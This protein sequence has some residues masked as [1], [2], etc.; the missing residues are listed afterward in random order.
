MFALVIKTFLRNTD[1]TPPHLDGRAHFGNRTAWL[2]AFLRARLAPLATLCFLAT[3]ELFKFERYSC[4]P[5]AITSE[6][7]VLGFVH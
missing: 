7:G 3:F 2:F 4:A 1:A 6:F 5:R